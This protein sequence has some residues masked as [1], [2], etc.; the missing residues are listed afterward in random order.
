[1]FCFP[2]HVHAPDFHWL[3]EKKKKALIVHV[4]ILKKSYTVTQTRTESFSPHS[5][6]PPDDPGLECAQHFP[7]LF[8]LILIRAPRWISVWPEDATCLLLPSG[9]SL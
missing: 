7:T 6:I 9:G 1:M 8:L 2:P 5:S 4:R 3:Q